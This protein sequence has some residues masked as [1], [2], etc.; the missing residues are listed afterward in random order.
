M[1]AIPTG[2]VVPVVRR[3]RLRRDRRDH[4]GTRGGRADHRT[5]VL[6][7]ASVGVLQQ[8]RVQDGRRTELHPSRRWARAVDGP[9]PVVV[10]AAASVLLHARLAGEPA[11][12][13]AAEKEGESDDEE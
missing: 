4:G 2:H 6:L 7:D 11:V 12:S 1:A 5:P 9:V 3:G 8:G 10:H 13:P